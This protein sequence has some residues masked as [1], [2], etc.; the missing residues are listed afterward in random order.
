MTYFNVINWS[1]VGYE[2][3]EVLERL[4]IMG[5]QL[6]EFNKVFDEHNHN[7]L[8]YTKAESDAKFYIKN[9]KNGNFDKLDGYHGQEIRNMGLPLNGIFLWGGSETTIPETFELYNNLLNKQVVGAGNFY[10]VG[11]TGGVEYISPSGNITIGNHALSIEE[12]PIHNHPMIDSRMIFGGGRCF[13]LAL[14]VYNKEEHTDS[15]GENQPHSHENSELVNSPYEKSG[16]YI[17]LC[18]IKKII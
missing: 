8:Y 6:E 18:F 17:K 14:I 3:S 1:E 13:P 15:V 7:S 16:K 12:L 5:D 11:D 2:T 4:N 9:I 10:K